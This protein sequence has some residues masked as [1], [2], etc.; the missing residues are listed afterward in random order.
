MV[1][2]DVGTSMSGSEHHLEPAPKTGEASAPPSVVIASDRPLLRQALAEALAAHHMTV[3]S[4]GAEGPHVIALAQRHKP[5]VLVVDLEMWGAWLAE[6]MAKLRELSPKTQVVGV[7][8]IDSPK[9]AH[10]LLAAGAS[11]YLGRSASLEDLLLAV[12]GASDPQRKGTTMTVVSR[13][14][15]ELS[16][17]ELQILSGAAHGLSNSEIASRLHVSEA[18]VKR[19]LAN[20][21]KKMGV[22]SRGEATRKALQ[23]GWITAWDILGEEDLEEQG[24]RDEG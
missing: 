11:A 9:Q 8:R 20:V 3:L 16:D 6:E 5:D 15:V 22:H 10:E 12:R 14:A 7:T 2:Y 4:E 13:E 21:Y 23:E 17:R 19:H 24:Q 1:G 18:T